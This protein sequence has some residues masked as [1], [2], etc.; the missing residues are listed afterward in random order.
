MNIMNPKIF[1]SADIEGTAGIDTWDETELGEGKYAY[2]A[3]Q[4]TREV[5]AAVEGA[6]LC[7]YEAT[8]KDAHD[9]ARNLDP[10]GLP[11]SARLIR[12]WIRDLWCMMGGLD[13]EPYDAVAFTGY[14]SDAM[15]VGNPLSHTMTTSVQKVMINGAYASEFTIN[16]YMAAYLGIPIV[17]LSGDEALCEAAKKLV[18]GI[19][20]VA[21]K[22][23]IGSAVMARHP[24]VVCDDIKQTM[25]EALRDLSDPEKRAACM[26]ALPDSFTISIEY[27]DWN[28]AHKYSFYPGA[29]YPDAKTVTF[30]TTDYYEAM[31]F[32]HFCL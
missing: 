27:K 18:P 10:M 4:M 24:A 20:T 30:T 28:T 32:M 23:G 5:C 1:I 17:F 21:S 26:L 15:S 14:H 19:R 6:E 7:G 11:K 22:T 25:Q 29:A 12:G 16:A 2:F 8:V 31:R 3:Q 9:S 13:R